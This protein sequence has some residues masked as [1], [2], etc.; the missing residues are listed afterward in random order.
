M[1][2]SLHTIIIDIDLDAGV[3]IDVQ[4][5]K[6]K[7]CLDITKGIEDALGASDISRKPKPEMAEKD[8][9]I[10]DTTKVGA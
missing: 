10:H 5:K 1:A 6:G 7:S 4:G 3:S 8:Q 9:K 2:K